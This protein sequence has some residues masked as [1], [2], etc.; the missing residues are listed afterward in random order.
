MTAAKELSMSYRI[1]LVDDHQ[2]FREGLKSVLKSETDFLVAGEAENGIQGVEL[3]RELAPDVV[4]MD[5]SMPQMNGIEATR[6]IHGESPGVKI[7]ILSMHTEKHF[8]LGAL[9][10]GAAGVVVKN[11]ASAELVIAIETVVSGKTYLSPAISHVVVQNLFDSGDTDTGS[12]VLSPREREI[13]QL[14]AM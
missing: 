2:M 8:I 11:S 7:I 9:K 3:S 4:I 14:I 12:K 6:R 1:L 13:L 5:I 10:A